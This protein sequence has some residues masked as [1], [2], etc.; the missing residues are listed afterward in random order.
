MQK[1]KSPGLC[2]GTVVLDR[3]NVRYIVS[4][5]AMLHKKICE[6]NY[7]GLFKEEHH[8]KLYGKPINN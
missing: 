1:A 4:D 5:I 7:I 2:T 8:E 3:W 6:R